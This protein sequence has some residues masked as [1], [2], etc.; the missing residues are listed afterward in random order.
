MTTTDAA[1]PGHHPTAK[2][3]AIALAACWTAAAVCWV[4][5]ALTYG[6]SEAEAAGRDS[7]DLIGFDL[8]RLLAGV[9]A[10]GA[11]TLATLWLAAFLRLRNGLSGS[12]AAWSA[13][14]LSVLGVV[15]WLPMIAAL[16]AAWAVALALFLVLMVG[17]AFT[18]ASRAD[19]PPTAGTRPSDSSAPSALGG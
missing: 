11:A 2:P 10:L 12:A 4:V 9:L 13:T 14:V 8:A 19:A 15:L 1:R 6:P 17:G 7:D 5:F 18:T 3:S 16:P